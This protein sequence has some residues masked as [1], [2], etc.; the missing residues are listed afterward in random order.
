M[1][2]G[3]YSSCQLLDHQAKT[4]KDYL[5]GGQAFGANYVG[6][7]VIMEHVGGTKYHGYFTRAMR[8]GS[9]ER[10][11]FNVSRECCRKYRLIKGQFLV[12]CL[13]DWRVFFNEKSYGVSFAFPTFFMSV[14]SYIWIFDNLIIILFCILKKIFYDFQFIIGSRFNLLNF[15]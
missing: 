6:I 10:G 4:A 11:I 9:I 5:S 2:C 13:Q 14:L 7:W 3:N 1:A 12:F 8:D 15:I